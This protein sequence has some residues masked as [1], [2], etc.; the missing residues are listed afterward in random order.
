LGLNQQ[1]RASYRS[2]AE[3]LELVAEV[4]G[5]LTGHQTFLERKAIA[6]STTMQYKGFYRELLL[7]FAV[8]VK[9]L[10]AALLGGL[11]VAKVEEAFTVAQVNLLPLGTLDMLLVEF[12]DKMYFEGRPAADAEKVKA[13]LF[14]Y[15]NHLQPADL[16]RSLRALKGFRKIAPGSSRYPLPFHV[17]QAIVMWLIHSGHGQAGL[18]VLICFLCYLRPSE[19][20]GLKREDILMPMRGARQALSKP[21]ILICPWERRVP[22]KTQQYDDTILLDTPGFDWV[23]AVLLRHLGSRPLEGDADVWT[24]TVE[25]LR[26]VFNAAVTGLGLPD[27][28]CLYQLRHGGASYDLLEG[29]RAWEAVRSRG[30]WMSDVTVKRY[31]KSGVIQRYILMVPKIVMEYGLMSAEVLHKAFDGNQV[32]PPPPL[33]GGAVVAAPA[34]TRGARKRPAAAAGLEALSAGS[35]STPTALVA[36]STGAVRRRP[37]AAA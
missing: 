33:L 35:Q 32:I 4:D 1:E 27:G 26:S 14:H 10:D 18:A 3:D 7:F 9:S 16:P 37:A 34:P 12:M 20:M 30:R 29:H 23:F 21:A 8:A 17:V 22:T 24:F 31:A 5:D 2:R 15:H 13:A 25:Q 28:T 6:K 19:L 36:I 11:L